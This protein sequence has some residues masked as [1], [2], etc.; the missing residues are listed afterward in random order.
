VSERVTFL[1][2]EVVDSVRRWE[3]DEDAMAAATERLD[4]IVRGVVGEY[5][6]VQ[7]K[8]RGEGDSHFLTFPNPADAIACAVA[9]QRAV[10]DEVTLPLRAACHVGSA[11]M[12]N[13][14]WYGTTVNRCARLRAAAHGRQSLVSVEA[15]DA[16]R[17]TLPDGVSL[18]SLGRHR[19]KDLDEPVEVF[20]VCA[21][22]LVVDHPPLSSLAHS[23][24]LVLPRS[25]FVGRSAE[26]ERVAALLAEGAVVTVTGAPGVGK[27]RLALE[28]AAQWSEHGAAPIR[29]AQPRVSP[30]E[31]V[32][33]DDAD[34]ATVTGPAV[35]TARAPI[36]AANEV[37]VRL[38]PL[39]E[40]DSERLLRDRLADDA[41][42]PAEAA[43]LCD[44]LPL[45]IELLARR[46][47]AVGA[48]VLAQRLA[49]DPLAVLGGDRRARP[50]RHSSVR[51]CLDAAFGE[52]DR[53]EQAG[54][55]ASSPGEPHWVARGWHEPDGP[56]P[57]VKRFLDDKRTG[58]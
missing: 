11:E 8:P 36:G 57:L 30:G 52:L 24:G 27:T 54:L 17:D 26:C 1:L 43:G 16:A 58:R 42:V 13:G 53:D 21:A 45:A 22:G 3:D 37:V 31:L 39:D 28:A 18:R 19:F 4:G 6:G 50:P 23:H 40:L 35:L 9:L 51:A 7:V 41:V 33:V 38:S 14:D 15:A 10:A 34:D 47:S 44:G 32:V 55:L 20:Q 46:A 5:R 48:D 2:T 56:L 25:S 49:A 29:V 12:R